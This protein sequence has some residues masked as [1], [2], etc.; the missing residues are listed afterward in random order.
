MAS[1]IDGKIETH[2][3]YRT[4]VDEHRARREKTNTILAAFDDEMSNR[5]DKNN[6]GYFTEPQ[7]YHLLADMFGAGT[8]TSLTTL[9]WFLL[10]MAVY[11]DEQVYLHIFL[12]HA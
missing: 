4:I 6:D 11:Q 9:R 3:I 10:F 1:L 7:M 2:K 8:D 5:S 12:S